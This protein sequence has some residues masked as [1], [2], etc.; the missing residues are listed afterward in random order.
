MMGLPVAKSGVWQPQPN[1]VVDEGSSPLCEP[2]FAPFGLEMVARLSTSNT[3]KRNRALNRSLNVNVLNRERSQFLKPLSRKMLRPMV[4][5]VPQVGGTITELPST[6]QP[7]A[8]ILNALFPARVL[9]S[10]AT[11]AHCAPSDEGRVVLKPLIPDCP[12]Q[13]TPLRSLI[14]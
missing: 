9:A 12:V 4:P 5:N 1:D 7:P 13:D 2:L 3:S 8:G 11:A 14:F 6:K 10:G